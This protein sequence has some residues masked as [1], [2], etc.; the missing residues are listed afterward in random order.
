MSTQQPTRAIYV[1]RLQ[2]PCGKGGIRKLRWL[3]KRLLRSYDLRCLSVE[4]EP[5]QKEAAHE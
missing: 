2:A 5:Q 3:L 1:L 4:E